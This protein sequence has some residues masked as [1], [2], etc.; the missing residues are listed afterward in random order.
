MSKVVADT[1]E[2]DSIKSYMPYDVTTNPSLVLK[3]VQN[4]QYEHLLGEALAMDDHSYPAARPQSNVA[5]ILAVNI[6]AE[7]LKIVPGKVSTEC[8]AHLSYDTQATIDKGLRIVDLYAKKGVDPKR[9]YIKIA[10]TWEGI[11]ACKVLQKQGIETN[12]TLLFSFAQAAA[13]ADAGASLI[14]PFVGR[15]MDWYK[16]KE[17]RTFA[18]HED[19]GVISVH[20]IYKY[21]KEYKYPTI[22]MAAS[23]R[24]VGEIR[25]LAGCDNI[26]IS[27]ALLGELEA[28][29]EPLPRKLWPEMGG[30]SEPKIDLTA[31]SYDLFK[32]LHGEDEMAVTKLAE[33]IQGFSKDQAQLES[34]VAK[35]VSK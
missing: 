14:S 1:G 30:C 29:T 11:R 28:S 19:P 12:M 13:C 18:P 16:A 4:P 9:L 31:D 7:L 25:E 10:S 3:A 17:G 8:D 27:P 23:F 32:K 34:M 33:G 24:N 6:G 21:Y 2:I 35:L 15:I 26:T 22:V 20:R 5:D